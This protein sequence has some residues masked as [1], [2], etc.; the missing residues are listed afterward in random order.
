MSIIF[1]SQFDNVLPILFN[2]GVDVILTAASALQDRVI[3][4]SSAA[5]STIQDQ[6][7]A[8]CCDTLSGV[9]ISGNFAKCMSR[10]LLCHITDALYSL[11]CASFSPTQ[12]NDCHLLSFT[13]WA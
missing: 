9:G 11:A 3:G 12:H 2:V 1:T 6:F 8:T 4:A 5:S 7:A 13:T 10:I